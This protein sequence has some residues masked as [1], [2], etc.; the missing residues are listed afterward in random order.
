[1]NQK[2]QGASTGSSTKDVSAKKPY[3]SPDLVEYGSVAKL[4]QTNP[5][6]GADATRKRACL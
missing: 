2:S 3:L 1:M 5:G 4:T 6:S